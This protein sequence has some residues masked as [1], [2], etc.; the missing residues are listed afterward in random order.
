MSPIGILIIYILWWWLVF[1]AVLPF[2]IKSRW[3]SDDDGVTGA[4]P[5]APSA[6][7][8]KRKLLQTSGIAL[9]L[10]IITILIIISGIIQYRD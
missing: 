3:E 2:G 6:P 8:L 1:F 7:M 10:S 4:E 9:G 5:G